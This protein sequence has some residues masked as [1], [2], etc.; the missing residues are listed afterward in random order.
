MNSAS[1]KERILI[2]DDTPD[3]IDLLVGV[4]QPDYEIM[5]AINGERALKIARAPNKPDMILLDIMMPG[6]DG[7]EVCRQIKADPATSEIPVIFITAKSEVADET[8]GFALGAVDYITKPISPPIVRA[9]V[10]THLTLH[11]QRRAMAREVRERTR[12]LHETRLEIIRHLARAAE[13]RDKDTGTHIIRMSHYSRLLGQAYG[14]N[15]EWVDRLFNA[16]PMH[17]VGKIGIPD[18]ILLK[19]GKLDEAEWEVMKRHTTYGGEIIGDNPSPLLQMARNIALTHHERWDGSGYPA[20]LK[21]EEI[22]LEGRIVALADVFDALT[23]VRPY[24]QA[25]TVEAAV[26]EMRQGAGKHFDPHLVTLFEGILPDCLNIQS[27]Y[28]DTLA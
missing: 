14:G 2:V 5:A 13:F 19:P 16:A 28:G 10:H 6:L 23:S 22:P 12:E 24:K 15:E 9:R 1:D 7:Y 27:R 26:A 21:G 11:D 25:W 18:H 17:D 4:L 8:Q 20:G 3:N